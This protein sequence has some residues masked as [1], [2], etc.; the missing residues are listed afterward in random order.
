MK[1]SA[2]DR[3]TPEGKKAYA[4]VE[5]RI[6]ELD[7]E[8]NKGKIDLEEHTRLTSVLNN[9]KECILRRFVNKKKDL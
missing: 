1:K 8:Y 3:M 4:L 9:R 6:R 5:A 7:M 2:Y